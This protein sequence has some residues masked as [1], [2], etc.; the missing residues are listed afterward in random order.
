MRTVFLGTSPFGAAALR[1]L[2]GTV[3]QP[4]LVVTQ[5]DR[6]AGRGRKLRP[7][8][9]K[10]VA[11][12]AGLAV[13][14]PEEINTVAA[15]ALIVAEAPEAIIVVAFGQILRPRLLAIPTL[16]CLNV[17]A[18]LLPRHRGASPINAQ[19][20]AGDARVGVTI[21]RMD[22]GL[23]TG[24]IGMTAAADALATETAGELHDRLAELA[25]ELLPQALDRLAA[26]ALVFEA[27][28]DALATHAPLMTKDDGVLDF[29]DDALTL[30]RRVRGYDPWPGNR[31]RLFDGQVVRR[32]SLVT[33]RAEASP[34]SKSPGALLEIG[35]DSLTVACGQGQLVVHSW[36]PEARRPMNLRDYLNG[37]TLTAAARFLLPDE[38]A[39][40][41]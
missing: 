14:Q 25:R 17:H 7:S 34:S 12:A 26:G 16:G 5:P 9:V 4:S 30:E 18:S 37:V 2:I 36:Q 39:P 15:R 11:T 35:S 27:Q 13:F 29:R 6:P 41:S 20:L 38:E 31:V 32:G 33:V 19:I 40:S 23:D 22:E 10:E 24:P 28:D 8:A 3:H 21:M 1:S